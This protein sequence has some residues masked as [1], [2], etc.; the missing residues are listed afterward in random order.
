MKRLALAGVAA[1]GAAAII[2]PTVARWSPVILWNTTASAP[3]GLYRMQGERTPH[4]GEW[5]AVR[6]P[7]PLAAWLAVRGFLPAGVPLLKRVAAT[8]PSDVCRIGGAITIDHVAAAVA[9]SVDRFGRRL[10]TWSGCHRLSRAEVFLLNADAASLDSRYF[11]A[12]PVGAI[13]GRATP[14][15]T[16]EARQ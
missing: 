8:A 7:R 14:V 2:G 12:L 3:L 16:W 9:R 10:P 4:A 5:I 11:G 6:P 13:I 1:L 15:W